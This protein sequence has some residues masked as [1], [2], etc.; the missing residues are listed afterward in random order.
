MTTR[1]KPGSVRKKSPGSRAGQRKAEGATTARAAAGA[2]AAKRAR[3]KATGAK[4]PAP[5]RDGRP[6]IVVESPTKARTIAKFLGS[7]FAIKAS[8]GHIMDLP[9][10]K[11][12]VDTEKDFTP[13]YVVMRGKLKVLK[14]LKDAA[15]RA[16]RIYLAPDPDRE[17]EAIAW[18]LKNYLSDTNSNSARLVFYEVTREAMLEALR[19]PEEIDSNKVDAQQARRILDRL[20]GY[21]VSPFLWTTL[22]YGL[23]AGRVQSVALRLICEREEEITSFK[24]QEYWSVEAELLGKTGE[25][26]TAKL[27]LAD[28]KKLEVGSEGTAKE[29]ADEI[30]SLAFSVADIREQEKKRNPFPPFTT[31]TLQQEAS[32]RLRFSSKKTMTIAQQLYEGIDLG[33]EGQV[34]LITYM[35]T[36]STRSSAQ[37]I[38]QARALVEQTLGRAYLPDSPRSYQSKERAQGAHEAVRPTSVERTPD[39]VK[40]FLSEP[41]LELYRLIWARFVASQM[42]P[43]SYHITSVDIRAGR[44][45]F[46][47]SGSR[48][49]FD[50]F[51]SIHRDPESPQQKDKKPEAVPR[52]SPGEELRL[53]KLDTF[54]HFTEP[55][56]R[57]TEGTLVKALDE[58]DIGRPSTYATIVATILAREYVAVDRGRLAPTDLGVTTNRLLL[59]AF[60]DIFNVEFTARMEDSLDFVESGERKWE[61]VVREFYGPFKQDLDKA[62]K[63][64]A[65]LR[66]EVTEETGLVC[67]RCGRK[68]VKKFGRRGPFY[69]C[70]GYPE[71]RFTRPIEEP[72]ADGIAAFAADEKCDVCGAP[73]TVK[74]G[75]FGRFLACTRYPDCKFT[76]PLEIGVECPREGCGGRLVERRSRSGRV[77]FAC[78]RYPECK[79]ATS[80]EPVKRKCPE[81]GYPVMVRRVTKKAG[82][83][84][85]CLRCNHEEPE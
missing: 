66:E 64:K 34:G 65:Q 29:L 39:H 35:R 8:N 61:E 49:T 4:P 47:A 84:L 22:R 13:H 76:K 43:A 42:A 23:S 15:A 50:G 81:C 5:S 18:H 52:L 14:E 27:L 83:T 38:E 58:N 67:E 53:S 25:P 41:Q 80:D 75:K 36:D 9:K 73:M 55:P 1:T 56:A 30:R 20:V 46:R 74:E 79:F 33:P 24:P 68:M 59:K 6:L 72:K 78:N 44:F 69:A 57:Y 16:S 71:C 32:K 77:F 19:H 21:L 3:R 31:S 2:S 37:S 26:F 51:T 60:P 70:S 7:D 17:G 40:R 85:R 28:G 63:A 62:E 11:L 82:T 12:G 10:A 48:M 54:Q 45:L